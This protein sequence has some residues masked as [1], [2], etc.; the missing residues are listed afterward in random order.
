MKVIF[1]LRRYHINASY[2]V[3]HLLDYGFQVCVVSRDFESQEDYKLCSPISI[4]DFSPSNKKNV[5]ITRLLDARTSQI[6]SN[7]TITVYYYV[8]VKVNGDRIDRWLRVLLRLFLFRFFHHRPSARIKVISPCYALHSNPFSE[9]ICSFIKP[10][11]FMHP[12]GITHLKQTLQCQSSS[13]KLSICMI[14]KLWS[15]RKNH[16]W[17]LEWLS[18]IKSDMEIEV[19]F[20]GESLK[21]AKHKNRDSIRYYHNFMTKFQLMQANHAVNLHEDLTHD[22][23]LHL[24]SLQNLFVLPSSREPFSISVLEALELKIPVLSSSGNGSS[25]Y[26]QPGINGELF[27]EH[28]CDSFKGKLSYMIS[29]ISIYS[30]SLVK[31]NSDYT[32]LSTLISTP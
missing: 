15:S 21:S 7:N 4:L 9:L 2:L 11:L 14:A 8:Q 26:V 27:K 24:L 12:I 3:K 10:I 1:D 19:N 29:N 22:E 5:I 16:V 32:E 6:I 30:S 28:N 18:S 25:C 31:P 13:P 23:C 20:I 17:L